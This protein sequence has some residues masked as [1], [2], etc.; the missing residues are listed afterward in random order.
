MKKKRHPEGRRGGAEGVLCALDR[1]VMNV[2]RRDR[3]PAETDQR[4]QRHR[5]IQTR[6]WMNGAGEGEAEAEEGRVS[7]SSTLPSFLSH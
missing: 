5:G 4:E 7:S 2:Y 1:P 3:Y 6:G